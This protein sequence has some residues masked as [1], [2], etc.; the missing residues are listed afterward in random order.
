VNQ[1]RR[2]ALEAQHPRRRQHPESESPC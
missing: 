1:R 2:S